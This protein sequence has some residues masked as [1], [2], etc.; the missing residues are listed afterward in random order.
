MEKVIINSKTINAFADEL[1]DSTDF[2]YYPE[3]CTDFLTDYCVDSN[4]TTIDE[5]NA[6]LHDYL[7]EMYDYSN[8]YIMENHKVIEGFLQTLKELFNEN[9]VNKNLQKQGVIS[10]KSLYI[11]TIINNNLKEKLKMFNVYS[12]YLADIQKTTPLTAKEE[13]AMFKVYHETKSQLVRNQIAESNMRFVLK[14]VLE[15]KSSKVSIEDLIA[16]GSTGMIKA[17][18]QFDYTRG[19]RFITYANFW[20]KSY[21]VSAINLHKHTIHIPWNKVVAAVKAQKKDNAKL[22]DLDREAMAV[23]ATNYTNVSL[24]S[25]INKDSTHTFAEVITDHKHDIQSTSDID[26]VVSLLT[27]CLPENE[28]KVLCETYGVNTDKPQSLRE[29]GA[30]MGFS[31]SRIKQLRDQALRRVKK[32][33]S[34]EVLDAAKETAY[35]N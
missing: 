32:Y 3:D 1:Q 17:I 25:T 26:D 30:S 20:I 22:S 9:N 8:E 5:V 27:A 7:R 19:T 21:I 28:K 18:D 23:M 10:F 16:A 24:D 11:C 31:H 35:S 12:K 14:T 6:A 2:F 29:I 4:C 34:K 13:F 33:T 15:Y